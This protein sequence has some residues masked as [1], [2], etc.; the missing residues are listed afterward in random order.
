MGSPAALVVVLSGPS[1]A[2]KDTILRAALQADAL[3]QNHLAG[4]V[5][6]KTRAPRPGEIDGDRPADTAAGAGDDGDLAKERLLGVHD[7]HHGQQAVAGQAGRA[8]KRAVR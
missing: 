2:G 1:G 8:G 4:V 7:A 5:T 3:D 6:A